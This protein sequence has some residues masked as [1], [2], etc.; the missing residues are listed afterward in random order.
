MSKTILVVD[1]EMLIVLDIQSQLEELG[2][3]VHTAPSLPSALALLER[4]GSTS[5]SST[6]T[7]RETSA[8]H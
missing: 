1:D 2:H 6:G 5:Q 3:T 7:C 8:R 4:N